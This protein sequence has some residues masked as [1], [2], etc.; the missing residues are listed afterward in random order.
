[1]ATAGIIKVLL[2]LLAAPAAIAVICTLIYMPIYQSKINTRLTKFG[3]LDEKDRKP[4]PT[5]PKIFL[6]YLIM[7]MCG[8]M[9]GLMIHYALFGE[10]ELTSLGDVERPYCWIS[11]VFS[12]SLVDEREVG[13]ELPGYGI[14]SSK[15]ENGFEVYFYRGETAGEEIYGFPNGFIGVK[16]TGDAEG[17]KVNVD[18]EQ[19]ENK[20]KS[21]ENYY[22]TDVIKDGSVW[23]TID[24]L[25]Y[26]G[27]VD[28]KTCETEENGTDSADFESVMKVDIGEFFE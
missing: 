22:G 14:V 28:I 26:F 19:K 20:G 1:M 7:A 2:V 17:F 15:K 27:T 8:A 16:Y 12:P 18:C 25:N 23:L 3:E 5:P 4:L 24:Y 10:K 13:G 11:E 9:I 6:I 21:F